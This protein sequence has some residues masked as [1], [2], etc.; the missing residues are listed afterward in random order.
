MPL[1]GLPVYLCPRVTLSFDLLTPKLIILCPCPVGHVPIGTRIIHFQNIVFT[2]LDADK[3]K[4]G[5]V[6]NIMSV[7]ANHTNRINRIDGD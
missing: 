4:N 5:Q 2:S 1:P 6:E 3:R 7:P